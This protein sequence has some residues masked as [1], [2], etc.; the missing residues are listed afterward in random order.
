MEDVLIERLIQ[1]ARL[2]APAN[3]GAEADRPD[4][5]PLEKDA[6]RR[7]LQ[8]LA[9]ALARP[10]VERYRFASTSH[11]DVEYEVT[12]DGADVTCTC[13]GFE[14]RGQ[15]RHARDI[16]AALAAGKPGAAGAA[17]IWPAPRWRSN[18]A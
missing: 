13:P 15:C 6:F 9:G 1:Q 3:P 2:D 4:R 17:G 11:P 18:A 10:S 8:A 12:I 16:K 5:T 14:Y 7:A